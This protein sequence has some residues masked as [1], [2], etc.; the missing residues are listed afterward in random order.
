MKTLEEFKQAGGSLT[1][2]RHNTH[3]EYEGQPRQYNEKMATTFEKL[4]LGHH[5]SHRTTDSGVGGIGNEF[6]QSRTTGASGLGNTT[7]TSGLGNT[8]SHHGTG[9]SSGNN[10][11]SGYSG[12]S[13]TA[14]D[15]L[16]GKSS[17]RTGQSGSGLSNTTSTGSTKPSLVDRLNPLKDTDGDGKR[18]FN[19]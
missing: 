4:G 6:D 2:G 17:T 13:G 3:E 15:G 19:E 16:D 18:G 10:N 14:R 5:E 12:T 8:S 1:G 9:I 7:G 11:T